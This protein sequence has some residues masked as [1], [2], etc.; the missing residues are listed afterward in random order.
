M[1]SLFCQWITTI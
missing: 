1:G